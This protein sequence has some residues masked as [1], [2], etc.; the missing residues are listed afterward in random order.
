MMQHEIPT[1]DRQGLRRFGL[2]TGAI[3]AVL[4]GLLLPWL[5]GH[6][7]SQWALLIAVILAV[8]AIAAPSALNPVYRVWM[9]IGLVLGVIITRIT[10]GGIFYA[11]MWPMG[12]MMRWFGYDPLHR[13]RLAAAETYRTA[14]QVRLKK[15]MENPY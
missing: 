6:N 11:L 1:L 3:I 12:V 13:Q 2:L 7:F 10:L 15:S 4:F 9:R 14:S 8:W 5:R